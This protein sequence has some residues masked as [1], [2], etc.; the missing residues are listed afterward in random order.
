[1]IKATVII[2]LATVVSASTVPTTDVHYLELVEEENKF[3]LN[4]SLCDWCKLLF[5]D[6]VKYGNDVNK[7]TVEEI[8][9]ILNKICLKTTPKKLQFIC[10][11][12][13]KH[14]K[15]IINKI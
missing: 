6:L 1:M 11:F 4:S 9:S 5:E 8:E 7:V 10:N 3:F 14:S 13:D 2:L 15:A 12:T